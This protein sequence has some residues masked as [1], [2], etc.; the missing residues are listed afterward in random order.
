LLAV[1]RL[2]DVFQPKEEHLHIIVNSYERLHPL[3]MP[4]KRLHEVFDEP[5]Y[6][7]I[8]HLVGE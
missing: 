3:S 2:Q 8:P 4:M 6:D 1:K 5:V 7:H